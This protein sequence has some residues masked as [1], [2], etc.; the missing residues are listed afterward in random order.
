MARDAANDHGVP[1]FGGYLK[2]AHSAAWRP[3]AD[4]LSK[5]SGIPKS[6]VESL[7]SGHRKRLP[8][9]S[10]QVEP[11]LRA[12]GNKVDEDRP[13][14]ADA[15]LG[16]M[17]AWRRAYDDAQSDRPL[18]CPLPS[19]PSAGS[20]SLTGLIRVAEAN[21][22]DLGVHKPIDVADVVGG[23][24][25]YAERDA[26]AAPTGVRAAL[27]RAAEHGGLIVLVGGS[28]VGKTRCVY[29]AITVLFP[30]WLL[31]HPADADQVRHAAA[32][33]P[34][35]LVVWLDELQK[36]LG[37]TTGLGAETLCA[38][39]RPGIVMVATMRPKWFRLYTRPPTRDHGSEDPHQTALD[40]LK[41]ADVIHLDARLSPSEQKRARALAAA[42]DRRWGAALQSNDYGPI[43]VIAA[44]P[45]LVAHWKAADTYPAAVLNAAIDATRLGARSPLSADL[46]CAAAPGYCDSRERAAAPANWFESALIYVTQELHG[47][48]AALAPVA[49]SNTMGEI[50]G[51]VVADYLQQHAGDARHSETVPDSTWQALCDYL[52]SHDDQGIVGERAYS[53]Q[54]YRYAEPLLR[55]AADA[56]R[57][58]AAF[59]LVQ[60]LDKLGREEELRA[61]AD[62]GDENA[63]RYLVYL[64]ARQGREEE[65]RA[66]ISAGDHYAAD[67]LAQLLSRGQDFMGH[68]IKAIRHMRGLSQ[69]DLAYPELSDSYVSLIE[70]RKR[71]PTQ[72]VLEL[73]ARKLDC[74]VSYLLNGIVGEHLAEIDS[75][76]GFV[77]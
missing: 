17:D 30:D 5:K 43:Q 6:T 51:Y 77:E 67:Y 11:L 42:G 32:A 18:S 64:L 38:L 27:T 44:A 73:L 47:A 33:V 58:Y 68:R 50:A 63:A 55:Q 76:L 26:D 62:A 13:G 15:V 7:I 70:S 56:G 9:W 21:P 71:I 25:I 40:V 48:V 34:T 41:L 36:Y 10:D 53:E 14:Q 1:T 35:K 61:R 72:L 4:Y 46:L 3:T 29:E 31:F 19:H 24:P 23:M 65:L 39:R 28:S 8:D 75:E 66:R 57:R 22:R 16:S 37:D 52:T 49:D 2:Q 59:L 12:L 60:L 54:L 20:A 45:H 74:S 69:A